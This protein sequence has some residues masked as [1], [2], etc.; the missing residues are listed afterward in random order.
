MPALSINVPFPVFQDQDGQPLDNGYVYIGTPYLD[1]QTNPVQVY[2]DDALTIPAAQPLRTIN[3]YV[4]N[5]GTPAQLYVNGVNFSIKVLDSKANLVYSFPDGSG[6]SPNASGIQYDPA[7]VGAVSTTVQAKLRETVSVKDFGADPTGAADST[8]AIQA[9]INA[10]GAAGGGIVYFPSGD[11][12]LLSQVSVN[13]ERITLLGGGDAVIIISSLTNN[14]IVVG[15]GGAVTNLVVIDGLRFDRPVKSTNGASVKMIRTGY[16]TVKNCVFKNSRFGVEV[17]THNDSLTIQNNT[18]LE[19]TYFGVLEYNVNETW[20]NDLT[21]RGNFFWHVEQAAVYISADGVG[22][23]SVGDTY[24]EDNVIVGSPAFGPLQ[25]QYAIKIQGAGSYNSNISIQR[26]TFEGIA[27]QTV[28]LTNLNRCRIEGNYFSGTGANDVGLYWDGGFGNSIISG[29]IFI[30]YNNQAAKFI[31]TGAISVAGNHFTSNV[32][33]GGNIAELEFTNCSDV[34]VTGNYFYSSSSQYA[35]E[36]LQVAGVSN[37]LTVI[38]NSFSRFAG[39]T[40]YLF[41]ISWYAYASKR[42]F[43]NNLG[44]DFTSGAGTATPLAGNAAQWYAGDTI[45]NTA[46]SVLGS[47]GSRYV[48]SGWICTAQGDPGTWHEMRTLTGT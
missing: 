42:F 23:S 26:N 47:P 6:I 44:N 16:S 4:S 45:R 22:V 8:A 25:T 17:K 15:N 3:G 43:A 20:A 38:G 10:V 29:N 36:F 34:N 48:V 37:N 24:I 18:F 33:L 13:Y 9:A 5:A 39:N 40:N 12:K 1:P 21:I 11:Y 2:F 27:L 14:G 19:G 30:G 35:I 7:G 31:S 46:P 41:D 32:T 28:Y